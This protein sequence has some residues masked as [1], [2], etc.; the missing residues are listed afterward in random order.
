MFWSIGALGVGTGAEAAWMA[1]AVHKPPLPWVSFPPTQLSGENEGNLPVA[2]GGSGS[3][4]GTSGSKDTS[5]DSQRG[6][7][8][9]ASLTESCLG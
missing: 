6:I 8:A 4:L 9:S 2:V 1:L 7:G 5:I 3:A